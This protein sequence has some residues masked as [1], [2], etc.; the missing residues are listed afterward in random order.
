MRT[1]P[2]SNLDVE[3]RTGH[4]RILSFNAYVTAS[5]RVIRAV[6]TAFPLPLGWSDNG[7]AGIPVRLNVEHDNDGNDTW[8]V[9][10]G[11]AFLRTVRDFSQLQTFL[12]WLIN[13]RAVEWLSEDHLLFHAG[14]VAFGQA[15]IILPGQS[16]SGKSTLTAA[17]IAQ[18]FSYFSDEVAL[19]DPESGSLLPFAK[20]VKLEP[21]SLP[22]LASRY[23]ALARFNGDPAHV[24]TRATYLR[25]PDDAWPSGPVPVTHVVF[26]RYVSGAPT[27]LVEVSRTESFARLL[28]HSFSATTHA[29]RGVQQIVRLLPRWACYELTVGE[30]DDAVSQ[31]LVLAGGVPAG[32]PPA[33]GSRKTG[34]TSSS[35]AQHPRFTHDAYRHTT[36]HGHR[37]T[38]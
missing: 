30:L 18:G 24:G 23:P 19:I 22:I 6:E 2:L 7:T 16:G 38:S 21:A 4:V 33:D 34:S 9:F 37:Q 17:L 11:S 29:A 31:L 15:G 25:P 8:H 14:T 12:I 1:Q 28:A 35:H 27:T 36:E 13:S 3:L 10:E 5:E 32:C 20:A 26:P